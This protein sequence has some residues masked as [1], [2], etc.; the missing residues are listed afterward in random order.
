MDGFI[1]INKPIGFTSRYV[2][3]TISKFF[4]TKKVGHIGTL[5]PFASGL[6]IVALNK[7]TK[8]IPFVLDDKKTYQATLV[9]GEKRDTLDIEGKVMESKEVKEHSI[10]EIKN[11]LNSFLGE[12]LQ[13]PPLTSAIHVDGKRLYEYFREGKE[14]KVKPRKI[15][16]EE[17]KLD[18]YDSKNHTITFTATVSKGTYVRVLGEDIAT[19]LGEVGY[20]NKLTRLEVFPIKLSEAQELKEPYKIIDVTTL[21]S[22]YMKVVEVNDDT[23]TDIKNGKVKYYD[24]KGEEIILVTSKDKT[25]IAIYRLNEENR[26]E[27]VRGLF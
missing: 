27:F 7:A 12:S 24:Y 10:E 15:F 13:T 11:A 23:A 26:L 6:L 19:K 22:R 18:E 1:L 25:P 16:I 20:L 21:L 9:L 14:V 4:H 2:T 17:I 8:A 5:D 3:N